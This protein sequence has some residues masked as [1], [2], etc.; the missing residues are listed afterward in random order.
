MHKIYT[1]T[2]QLKMKI[3]REIIKYDYKNSNQLIQIK[4]YSFQKRSDNIL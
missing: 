1:I 2:E 3:K 4:S